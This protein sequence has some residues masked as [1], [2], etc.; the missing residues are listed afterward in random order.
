MPC[1]VQDPSRKFS[2]IPSHRH[3]KLLAT[4]QRL[5]QKFSKIKVKSKIY[6]FS[7]LIKPL[8]TKIRSILKKGK[9][10]IINTR[11]L[12]SENF[13][14]LPKYQQKEVKKNRGSGADLMK[15]NFCF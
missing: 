9:G 7:C 1:S 3:R 8:L 6:T 15:E 14:F 2:C 4:E 13:E 11:F 12:N 5:S 10:V